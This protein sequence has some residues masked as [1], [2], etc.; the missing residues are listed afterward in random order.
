M[1]AHETLIDRSNTLIE[2]TRFFTLASRGPDGVWASTVNFIPL[3][4][5]LRFLWYSLRDARHSR[6]IDADPRVA[7]TVFRTD[8]PTELGL[9]GAQ[10]T[11]TAHEMNTENVG[12]LYNLFYERN[13]PDE[14]VRQQWQLPLEE[15]RGEGPRRFYLLTITKWWLVDLDLWLQ[16]KNDRRIAVDL[17]ALST[18]RPSHR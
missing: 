15:F 5:P 11:G 16:T 14:Q 12:D 13:F 1:P 3:R 2:H 4:Q 10:L 8:L 9:D 6:N 18:N 17:D 7:G